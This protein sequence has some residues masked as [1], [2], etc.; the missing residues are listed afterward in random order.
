MY[1][2]MYYN[3]YY[4]LC[5]HMYIYNIFFNTIIN[6]YSNVICVSFAEKEQKRMP[7]RMPDVLK[8]NTRRL[9]RRWI[10]THRNTTTSIAVKAMKPVK[11]CGRLLV[12]ND[13]RWKIPRLTWTRKAS[14]WPLLKDPCRTST[15][16]SR[17]ILCVLVCWCV[18]VFTCC[19]TYSFIENTTLWCFLT[20]KNTLSLTLSLSLQLIL[21]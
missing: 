1:F 15:A 19:K 10:P 14:S 5:I 2:N 9:H 6:I 7:W 11:G 16:V 18:G 8:N 3:I 12:G 17:C 20:W 13:T 4:I 21:Q